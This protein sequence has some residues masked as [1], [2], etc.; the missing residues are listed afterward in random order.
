[1]NYLDVTYGDLDADYGA[2][3]IAG[4]IVDIKKINMNREFIAVP[5]VQ[6]T[7]PHGNTVTI[8][9]SASKGVT[10]AQLA[11]EALADTEA[12]YNGA[13]KALLEAYAGK[14]KTE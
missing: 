4:S 5:Y 12:T 14:L 1:M 9:G 3:K 10:V 13:E 7:L 11:V 6:V 8:Y 2:N